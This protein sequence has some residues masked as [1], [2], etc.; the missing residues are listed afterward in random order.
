MYIRYCISLIIALALCC[1]TAEAQKRIDISASEPFS[2]HIDL[3][4]GNDGKD[5]IVTFAFDEG[6]NKLTMTL[7]SYNRIVVLPQDIA[8]KGVAKG[9]RIRI[10]RLPFVLQAPQN[11]SLYVSKDLKR[12]LAKRA[13]KNMLRHWMDCDNL[14]AQTRECRLVND[15]VTQTFQFLYEGQTEATVALHDIYLL[16][17]ISKKG[18]KQ[19]K[20]ELYYGTDLDRTYIITIHRDPCLGK[21]A[22]IAARTQRAAD[23]ADTWLT[24][25][26]GVESLER[27]YSPHADSIFT[28]QV[29]LAERTYSRIDS[30]YECPDLRA[31]TNEYNAYADSLL[32]LRPRIEQLRQAHAEP[33]KENTKPTTVPV[34]DAS[35]SLTNIARQL[36]I[37]TTQSLNATDYARKADLLSQGQA[38][39]ARGEQL[40]KG[41]RCSAKSIEIFQKARQYFLT[42]KS[43][44]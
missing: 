38:L 20:Q 5:I 40:M 34:P 21:E 32:T 18:K 15:Y 36:D 7:L 26:K 41:G 23:V 24:L 43:K 10:E 44:K 25:Q 19:S 8:M 30:V 9:R 11:T 12:M 42:A 31:A 4:G 27:S 3:S 1:G 28:D 2:D 37:V 16:R 29:D 13:P 6:Q 39:V 33:P 14:T 17:D 22:E 35:T